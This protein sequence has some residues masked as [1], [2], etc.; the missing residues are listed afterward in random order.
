V[1]GLLIVIPCLNEEAHLPA[2]LTL[3]CAD[4][5]ASNAR[6]VVA[7]GGSTDTSADIV[8]RFAADDARVVLLANPKRIQSAAVNLAVARCAADAD[9]LIRVDAHAS[10]PADFLTRLVAAA[11]ETGA[12][13]VTISMRAASET[14]ACFQAAAAAAQNSVLGAGGSPHRKGGGR[15]WVDHGHHALFRLA[16]YRGAGGYDESFTHN[17]D[18]ELDARITERGGRILLAADVLIDYFPRRTARALARQY[19]GYGRGRARTAAKHK[20]HLK[21]RQLLPLAVAPAIALC[22]LAPFS[23]WAAAPAAAWLALCL[24]FGALLGARERSICAAFAG[25]PAAIMHAAWS[26]GFLREMFTPPR[27]SAAPRRAQNA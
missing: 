20:Q 17:E 6:I 21:P 4:P 12:D 15:R 19:F 18:A 14:G 22:A 9:T 2:L 16:A 5:A 10:Y 24:G 13:T 1:S 25:I 8:R 26:A 3:L 11:E 23:L 7:D 27:K